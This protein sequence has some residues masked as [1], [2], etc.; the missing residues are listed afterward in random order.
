MHLADVG[1]RLGAQHLAADVGE[2]LDA[3]RAVG[4]ELAVVLGPDLALGDLLDVAAAADPVAAQLGQA[5]H[6]VDPRLGV[7]VGAGAVVDA[8]AAARP[9]IGSRS[10]S[11]IATLSGPTWILRLPRIGPV[12]TFEL[13]AGGDVGHVSLSS[14]GG[15]AGG[16]RSLPTPVSAGSGSAGRAGVPRHL[17]RSAVPRGMAPASS[18]RR[19]RRRRK[20]L[21]EDLRLLLDAAVGVRDALRFQQIGGPDQAEDEGPDDALRAG[22]RQQR[23]PAE[24]R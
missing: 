6:D 23:R 15:R 10:I 18:L 5:G 11:R 21:F 3:A 14:I 9:T 13:G 2:G 8:Q 1:A 12:V 19:R 24:C 22:F 20:A 4:A 17:N 16:P 7:G